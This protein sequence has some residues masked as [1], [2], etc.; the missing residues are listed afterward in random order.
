MRKLPDYL[1]KL[2]QNP[3]GR[4]GGL[5]MKK[6]CIFII[7]M[8]CIP[9]ASADDSLLIYLPFDDGQPTDITDNGNNGEYVGEVKQADGKFGKGIELD[10]SN[11]VDIPWSDSI[12][13]GSEDFTV[14][15]W[16][17]YSEPSSNGVLVWGYDVESGPHAQIWFRTEPGSSRIRGLMIDS[18]GPNVIVVTTDPYND[19]KWHHFAAVRRSDSLSL[20]I[21]GDLKD[22]QKGNDGSVTETQTFGIQLGRKMGNRDMYKGI[23]DEFRFWKRPLSEDEIRSNMT[24]SK[25]AISPVDPSGHLT[26]TWGELKS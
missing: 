17:K 7:V 23:L 2:T 25:E 19:D 14:E 8:V 24:K 12:D 18:I 11:Y 13:V 21:D 20:Y 1:E 22:S 16:F 10:G 5:I 6:L 4:H 26:I 9:L 15:I 3:F